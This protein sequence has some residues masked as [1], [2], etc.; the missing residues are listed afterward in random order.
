[1]QRYVFNLPPPRKL[2]PH[3]AAAWRK[4]YE[5]LLRYVNREGHARVPTGHREGEWTIG[6]WVMRQ[7]RK[8]R[9]GRLHEEYRE[10]LE[11][12]PGWT[13]GRE[14]MAQMP[15][16]E[17]PRRGGHEWNFIVTGDD[18]RT[19]IVVS[20]LFGAGAV[21]RKAAVAELTKEVLG[22]EFVPER[23]L[24]EGGR[25]NWL[26]NRTLDEGLR[27]GNLDQ[28]RSGYIRAVIQDATYLQTDDWKICLKAAGIK[29]PVDRDELIRLALEQ[30]VEVF[31]VYRNTLRNPESL[32]SLHKAI[33]EMT[34]ACVP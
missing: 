32:K 12:L 1:M 30:A 34:D 33:D 22:N 14:G 8:W 25:M 16:E 24:L 27:R 4:S 19:S 5:V 28:P 2:P 7:R 13:W 10:L 6:R 9:E 20:T 26:M 3:L 31:G 23:H 17:E 29:G 15:K 11:A 21:R 18:W